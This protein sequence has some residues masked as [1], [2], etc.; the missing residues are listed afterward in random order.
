MEIENNI[1]DDAVIDLVAGLNDAMGTGTYD[2]VN[3]GVIG[4]DAIKVAMIYK[5]A[6]VSKVGD[7][8]ILDSSVDARFIDTLNRPTLAQSFQN[9]DTGTVFTVA[10][11][12]LKS[13]GSACDSDPDLGDGAGN[14]NLTR[15]A[16]AE[17]MVDWLADDPTDSGSSNNLII[18]DLNSYDK[19]DPID[20]IL[21]GSDDLAMTGDDY[22]DLIL[23][24]QG[25]YAY[26][27][28]FDG[29]T[30]YLDH[31]LA[32][33]SMESLVT[34]VNFWHINADE[35]SLIDYDM[36]FKLPAQDALYAPD[37]F[38][39]SDHDPVIIGLNLTSF[40]MTPIELN[41]DVPPGT[42]LKIPVTITNNGLT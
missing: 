20:A 38:R 36:S 16:A 33:Q 34:S 17:A 39:S 5:P 23:K 11:N 15:K 1:D 27:Y 29:Q 10:V 25:D 22:S 37:A 8:A 13:K 26:G 12:H 21:A 32:S 24:F 14:C 31:A 6:S 7:Y 4:T 30:G 3:T 41:R 35:P 40:S 28:V 19:E 2:Y 42:S 9:P 18:G